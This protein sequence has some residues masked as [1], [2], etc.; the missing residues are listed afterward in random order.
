MIDAKT[1]KKLAGPTVEERVK[2]IGPTIEKLAKEGK[3]S[4]RCGYD[5]SEDKDL[6]IN[7]GYSRSDEWNQAKT[8]LEKLGFEVSFYYNEGS[9]FVD[10][11]TVIK[12]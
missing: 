10:M 9:Q 7:G 2:A 1:A 3:R 6:W 12:W 11:Y 4:L 8:F 5:Y